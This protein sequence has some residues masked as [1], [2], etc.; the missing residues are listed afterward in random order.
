MNIR[1][2]TSEIP[3]NMVVYHNFIVIN[4]NSYVIPKGGKIEK[5]GIGFYL[6]CMERNNN[7]ICASG[8]DCTLFRLFTVT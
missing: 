5:K 4:K 7:K 8:L 2:S 3:V 6:Y 1:Y